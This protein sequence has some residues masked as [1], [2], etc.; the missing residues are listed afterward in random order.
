MTYYTENSSGKIGHL[1]DPRRA[2]LFL[3]ASPASNFVSGANVIV[4]GGMLRL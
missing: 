4:K 1:S 3:V 2:L